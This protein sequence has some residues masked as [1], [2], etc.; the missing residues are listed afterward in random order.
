MNTKYCKINLNPYFFKFGALIIP[1]TDLVIPSEHLHGHHADGEG[2]CPHN[3]FP[4]V[5]GYK[6]AMHSE[7]SGQHLQGWCSTL[8]KP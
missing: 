8:S 4:W 5:G 1:A 6:K 2:D 7:E 3:D